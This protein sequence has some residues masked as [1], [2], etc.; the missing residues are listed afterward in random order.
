[1][2]SLQLPE[3][4]VGVKQNF[5][6]SYNAQWTSPSPANDSRALQVDKSWSVTCAHYLLTA[7]LQDPRQP[8]GERKIG[9]FSAPPPPQDGWAP[10]FPLDIDVDITKI[11]ANSTLQVLS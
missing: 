11:P 4:V 10:S 8:L 3:W 6:P 1:M 2:M 5:G 9:W 7:Q